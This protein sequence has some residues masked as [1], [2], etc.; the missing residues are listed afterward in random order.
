MSRKAKAPSLA[1]LKALLLFAEK[2]ESKAVAKAMG[3]NPSAVSRWLGEL[4]V[5]YGLLE[6]RGNVQ[7]L[8]PRGKEAVVAIRALLRQYEHLAEWLGEKQVRPQVF[9]VATGALTAQ[10]YLPRALAAFARQYPEWQVRI[11]VR[12]GRER[13]LGTFD[14]TFDLAVV[15]HDARQIH[16][17]LTAERGEGARLGAE[18]L[19]RECL[20]LIARQGTPAGR[21]LSGILESQAIPLER[22]ADFDLVGLDGESGLRRQLERRCPE[23]PLRFLVEGG[24]WAAARELARRGVGAAVVPLSLLHP[25]DRRDLVIRQ[26][27]SD[28]GVTERLVSRPGNGGPE[29][30]ALRQA[31]RQ[32]ARDQQRESEARWHGKLFL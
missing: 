10:L 13:I 4:R 7:A 23:R 2:K 31:V 1:C 32:A 20:C 29:H 25:D 8:T 11:Q 28:A 15:S 3:R 9:V 18:D 21:R 16:D 26:L 17:L 6:K 22:L 24:G 12:R 30:E 27:K 14:G 19:A 5:R